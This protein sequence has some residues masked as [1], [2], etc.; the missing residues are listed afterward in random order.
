MVAVAFAD[1]VALVHLSLSPFLPPQDALSLLLSCSDVLKQDIRDS[2]ATKA[3]LLYYKRDSVHFGKKCAGDVHQL[4]PAY[5]RGARGPCACNW[6]S[7]IGAD[8]IP[9][10]LPLPKIL[11]AR[12]HLLETMLLMYKGIRPHCSKV[13]QMFRGFMFSTATMQP[14]VFSLAEALEKQ[15]S[16]RG[17]VASGTDTIDT[18]DVE[19]L[20]R[21]MN[22]AQPGFGSIFFSTNNQDAVVANVVEAHLRGIE[23]DQVSAAVTCQFCQQYE[24][25]SL[26]IRE[27]EALPE[28]NDAMMQAHCSAVYQPL[29]KF[30]LTHLKHVRYVRAVP[31][32]SLESSSGL[33]INGLFAGFTPTGVFCGVYVTNIGIPPRWIED[34]LAPGH[35]TGEEEP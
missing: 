1:L 13:L 30:M 21:L 29:K 34:R 17:E 3:L 10:D 7:T 28:E 11:D 22:I 4:I 5:V 19:Q 25:S 14:V 16:E 33:K 9:S 15:R 8:V 6:D 32:W 35:F 26:F 24:Q 12:T 20:A 31:E 23:V 2:I 27:P 18:D